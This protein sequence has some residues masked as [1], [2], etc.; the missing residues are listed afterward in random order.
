MIHAKELTPKIWVEA[1]NYANHIQN[2]SPHRCVKDMTPFEAWRGNK[3]EVTHFCVFISRAWAWIP[4]E[5]RKALYPQ[6][7]AC[8][9]YG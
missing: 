9:F 5:N 7:I 3:P 8:I 1:L 4:F 6:S 2:R